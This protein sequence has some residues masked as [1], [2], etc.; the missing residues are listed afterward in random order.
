MRTRS[1]SLYASDTP[2]NRWAYLVC[3]ARIAA[4]NADCDCSPAEMKHDNTLYVIALSSIL[5]VLLARFGP[6]HMY[7]VSVQYLPVVYC[8]A[9]QTG[10]IME[11]NTALYL[12]LYGSIYVAVGYNLLDEYIMRVSSVLQPLNVLQLCIVF[13]FYVYTL[14]WVMFMKRAVALVSM[15]AY[16][17]SVVVS[18]QKH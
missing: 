16:A 17:V 14:R 4:R 1:N 12:V 10:A 7:A 18:S 9:I 13:T 5:G 11:S 8:A 15:L 2:S 3:K 6:E